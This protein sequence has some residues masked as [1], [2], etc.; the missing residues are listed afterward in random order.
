MVLKVFYFSLLVIAVYTMEEIK[1]EDGIFILNKSNFN[2]ATTDN[3]FI[4]VEF[5][6]YTLKYRDLSICK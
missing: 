1:T 4:L 3:E 5:C 6:E 2:T